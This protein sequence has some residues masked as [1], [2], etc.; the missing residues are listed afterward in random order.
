MTEQDS[1]FDLLATDNYDSISFSI[2]LAQ[3]ELWD[4]SEKIFAV[5]DGKVCSDEIGFAGAY[6]VKY[7]FHCKGYEDSDTLYG[8]KICFP[9]NQEILLNNEGSQLKIFGKGYGEKVALFTPDNKF[10][11]EKAIDKATLDFQIPAGFDYLKVDITR[12]GDTHFV[13]NYPIR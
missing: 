1:T 9:D 4:V 2:N 11:G 13:F 8:W 7:C 5:V 12:D 10:V 3:G 6:D